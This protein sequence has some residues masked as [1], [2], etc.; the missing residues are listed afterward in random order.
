MSCCANCRW[1]DPRHEYETI[2]ELDE[3][4]CHRYPPS[5]PCIAKVNDLGLATP[6]VIRGSVFTTYP[7]TYALEW[8]GEF[9]RKES[10]E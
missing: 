2:T 3:G 9:L 4:E 1:W 5:I 8:C 6:E 7:I 10:W